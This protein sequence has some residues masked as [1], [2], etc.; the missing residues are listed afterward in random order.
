MNEELQS[1]NEELE[2]INTELR[3]RTDE[4]NESNAFLASILEGLQAGVAVLDRDLKILVWNDRAA[5]LWGLRPDEAQGRNWLSLDIGLPVSELRHP[6]RACLAGESRFQQL[7]VAATNRRGRAIRCTV[8]CTPLDS[9]PGGG[10]RGVILVM[11]TLD[12]AAPS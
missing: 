7:E 3:Q 4:L 11:E 5:D 8:T 9:A 1:T 6:V 2:T 10:I 12:D